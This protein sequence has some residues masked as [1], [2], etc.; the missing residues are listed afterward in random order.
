MTNETVARSMDW[1][2]LL[3]SNVVSNGNEGMV[4]SI[5][6]FYVGKCSYQLS[7]HDFCNT[8]FLSL[9]CQTHT[10]TKRERDMFNTKHHFRTGKPKFRRER[11]RGQFKRVFI[12]EEN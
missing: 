8:S 2:A 7:H 1:G 4:P 6:S 11:S 3:T 9:Q 12:G 5:E 10:G